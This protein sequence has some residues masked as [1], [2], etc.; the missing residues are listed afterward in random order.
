MK[1]Y[2]KKPHIALFQDACREAS[3]N[4]NQL[5]VGCEYAMSDEQSGLLINV[6]FQRFYDSLNGGY[7]PTTQGVLAEDLAIVLHHN[8]EDNEKTYLTSFEWISMFQDACREVSLDADQLLAGCDYAVSDE[9]LLLILDALE[10]QYFSSLNAN[11][12]PGP[13]GALVDELRTILL[14]A[15]YE[16]A[17]R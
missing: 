10:D 11:D 6:L 4:V 15:C 16:D 1:L 7:E 2:L 5:L 14:D 17:L 12:K 8:K 13:R 9:Q 3:L